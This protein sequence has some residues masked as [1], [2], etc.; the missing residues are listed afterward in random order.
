MFLNITKQIKSIVFV[1]RYAVLMYNIV[2]S[3]GDFYEL[4][5]KNDIKQNTRK[6]TSKRR[7]F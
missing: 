5:Q 2:T 4:Y 3:E 7:D 1:D 6:T